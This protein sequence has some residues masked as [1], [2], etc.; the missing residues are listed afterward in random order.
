MYNEL[1]WKRIKVVVMS[2]TRNAV[3]D[4]CRHVGSNP[5]ASAKQQMEV[6]LR[7]FFVAMIFPDESDI[8]FANDIASQ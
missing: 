6:L 8:R 2:R 5:T 4:V 7:T 1:V 3:V